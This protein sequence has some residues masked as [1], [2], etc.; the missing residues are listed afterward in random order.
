MRHLTALKTM[1]FSGLIGVFCAFGTASFSNSHAETTFDAAAPVLNEL[2]AIA[3]LPN[4]D[5]ILPEAFVAAEPI[6][7]ELATITRGDLYHDVT[8]FFASNRALST[9]IDISTPA[10]QF[11]T[12]FGRLR[13]GIAK[14]TIPKDHIVGHLETQGWASSWLSEP[15]PEKYVILETMDPRPE[16]TVMAQM[17]AVM[18]KGGTSTLLYIHGFNVSVDT[19]ARRAGQLT[20]DLNW[21]G[22]SFF[23]SWPSL[24]RGDPLG[25]NADQERA[26]DS[27]PA[28]EAVINRIAETDTDR[29]VIIAHSMG[30]DLLA[31]ALELMEARKSPALAKI[32]TVILAAPDINASIFQN[33]IVPAINSIKQQNEKFSVTVYA[34]ANDSALLLSDGLNGRERIGVMSS[35]SDTQRS[36]FSPVVM[37][38]AS[39][40][41][42]NFF[43][44]TYINDNPSVIADVYCMLQKGPEPTFRAS[45][46][47]VPDPEGPG[48][49]I[50]GWETAEDEEEGE[51]TEGQDNEPDGTLDNSAEG[52]QFVCD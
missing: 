37:V 4:P 20:Y 29:I 28:L 32:E 42:T 21:K 44:H 19:A 49:R 50:P 5:D 39:L 2:L 48:F 31:Q 38:D 16:D 13:Y 24:N 15:N 41:E 47:G 17:E 11:T 6:L 23:F 40:A 52:P 35:I 46:E 14:V 12:R 22:P 45:L 25:Y 51:E 34:S 1:F 3:D 33:A 43:G 7:E 18:A 30:T 27:R 10:E 9:D 8:L 36:A 26:R